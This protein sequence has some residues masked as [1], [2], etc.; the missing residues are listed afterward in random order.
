MPETPQQNSIAE[1]R[2]RRLLNMVR[3]MLAHSTLLDFLWGNVL[4]IAVYILNQILSKS[5]PKT[6][7]KLIYGKKPSLKHFHVWGYKAVK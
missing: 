5:M 7:Y 2:N 6:P 1:R 4:R 3:C